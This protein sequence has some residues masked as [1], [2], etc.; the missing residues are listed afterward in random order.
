MT[1]AWRVPR[2]KAAQV[3]LL[4][5]VVAALVTGVAGLLMLPVGYALT[6]SGSEDIETV[7]LAL[8][9]AV[10]LLPFTLAIGLIAAFFC[11][12]SGLI[13]LASAAAGGAAIGVLTGLFALL[14][15][16]FEADLIALLGLPLA[17]AAIGAALGAAFQR[18]VRAIRPAAFAD[19]PQ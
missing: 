5:L 1:S 7:G 11:R 19:D 16:G 13:G 15:V 8:M 2:A 12:R 14:L 10:V 3:R 17:G 18:V 9:T 4:D 6:E